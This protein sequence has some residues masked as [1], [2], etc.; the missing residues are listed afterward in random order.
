M[1]IINESVNTTQHSKCQTVVTCMEYMKYTMAPEY[2]ITIIPPSRTLQ[3]L[4]YTQIY[5]PSYRTLITK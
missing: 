5:P 2:F 1:K 4:Y 3:M